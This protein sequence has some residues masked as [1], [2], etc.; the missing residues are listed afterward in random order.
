[1]AAAQPSESV[2]PPTDAGGVESAWE[3]VRAGLEREHHRIYEEIKNYPRPIPA[4][5]VQFNYLLEERADISEELER[6]EAAA[7]ESRR[8][9]DPGKV[10]EEFVR[11][12]RYLAQ[13]SKAGMA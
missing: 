5:D 12:S 8:C 13:E 11:S 2:N 9:G 4:C 10:L 6:L 1:M 3:R 7:K